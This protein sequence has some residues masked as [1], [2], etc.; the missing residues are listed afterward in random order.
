V[1]PDRRRQTHEASIVR[2]E[3]RRLSEIPSQGIHGF[4]LLTFRGPRLQIEYL[5]EEGGTSWVEQW[6]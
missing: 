2:M 1:P 4:A 5:D 3:T 6:D